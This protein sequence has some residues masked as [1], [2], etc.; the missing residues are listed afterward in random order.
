MR[1]SSVY[2]FILFLIL[3]ACVCQRA[4]I[5]NLAMEIPALKKRLAYEE[6]ITAE[7]RADLNRLRTPERLDS[8]ATSLGL[9]KLDF[10]K[11]ILFVDMRSE[12][13]SP[14]EHVPLRLCSGAYGGNRRRDDR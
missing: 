13:S 12:S 14:Q 7:L 10:D 1:N 11:Q 8:L 9:V 5:A 2:L 3:F 4:Y 6:A